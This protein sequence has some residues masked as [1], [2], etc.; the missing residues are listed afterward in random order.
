MAIEIVTSDV[1]VE[2]A[3]H[4]V[5][6]A[7][8]TSAATRRRGAAA[9]RDPARDR[10]RSA[11]READ[12]E[13][14]AELNIL[15]PETAPGRRRGAAAAAGAPQVS[16]AVGENE[17]AVVL[18]ET[19]GG[20]FNW[21]VADARAAAP[22]TR[23]GR[24]G[25]QMVLSFRIDAPRVAGDAGQRRGPVLDWIGEKLADPVRA[26]V[27]R[28][29]VTKTIDAAVKRI[30]G[31]NPTGPVLIDSIDP[32][33]WIPKPLARVLPQ[34]R[35]ARI[36]LMVHGT[37]SSTGGSF[38]QLAGNAVG[39]AFL[40]AA[41]AGY[42]I[43]LGHDH[44]TLADDPR[45]NAEAMLATLTALNPPPGSVID[46]VAF[47]RGGLVYRVFAEQLLAPAGLDVT[48]GK[49]IFVGCT[50][51]G[52]NLAEPEN[53][54]DMVDLYTNAVMAAA[55]GIALLS[56]SPL[57]PGVGFAI[58]TL[59]RFVQ[60][61][62][63]V[64]I[65]ERKLPGLAA[66]EPDGALVAALNAVPDAARI[67]NYHAVTS[68]FEPKRGDAKGFTRA[69]SKFVADR[70]TDRLFAAPN[71]LVVHTGSM[72]QF[73]AGAAL[74]PAHIHAFGDTGLIYHTIYF[75][76][77][78]VAERL[79]QWLGLAAKKVTPLAPKTSTATARR[80]GGG[81]RPVSIGVPPAPPSRPRNDIDPDL[82]TVTF[83]ASG[84]ASAAASVRA[85]DAMLSVSPVIARPVAKARKGRSSAKPAAPPKRRRGP[86]PETPPPPDTVERYLAAEM[87]PYPPIGA[88]VNVFVIVSPDAIR[89]AAHAAAATSDAP[90][91]IDA[92]RTLT[93][94]L[95]PRRN[96]RLVDGDDGR[97]EIDA[98]KPSEIITRLRVQGEA[99][100]DAELIVEARQ[101]SRIIAS[102]VLKPIFV[103]KNA[104]SLSQSQPLTA[105][106]ADED[107]P[108]LRIYEFRDSGSRITLRFD[109]MGDNPTVALSE[110]LTL[111][112]AFNVG[113]YVG[114][115]L[116][117]VEA[118]WNLAPD[119]YDAFLASFSDSAILRANALMPLAIRTALWNGRGAIKAI[120]IISDEA[121]IPWELLFIADPSGQSDERRGVL[122]EWGVVRW[123]HGVQR[124]PRTIGFTG[125]NSRSVIP[126]YRD[127][128][129]SLDGVAQ[130]HA[131]LKKLL[132]GIA[133]VPATSLEVCRFLRD[134]SAT[135]D[136]LHF[137]CHGES[138][139]KAVL[140]AKLLMEGNPNIDGST[141]EDGLS[142]DQ[143]KVNLRMATDRPRS[144]VFLN[145]CQ[146]GRGGRGIAGVSGFADSFI[147]PL[148]GHGAAVFV[149][150][151]WSIETTL[152]ENFA[153]TFYGALKS[154]DTLV[155]AVA[156]ARAACKQ[157]GD[158]TWL[159]YTIFGHPLARAAVS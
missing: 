153:K 9:A 55:R 34:D 148:S 30:E 137:A 59:G 83:G 8:D 80:G 102:F 122:S 20:V 42:D 140:T 157:Q 88:P 71:D 145:S 44:A 70:I 131:M 47:S 90:V 152:A 124:P 74:D 106:A 65:S 99:P 146:T 151:L 13:I 48:L 110:T 159:A 12:F 127:P 100:G 132:P 28:F 60:M 81:R 121:L 115:V 53:W 64:A 142:A 10:L 85:L 147:R 94:E 40:D 41:I 84:P 116:A 3:G 6:L 19:D 150:A 141:R 57:P 50:N 72:I 108:V 95:I 67:A 155:D 35:P 138:A 23:R 11:L 119:S 33:A 92:G 133:P 149:G 134:G 130:E 82:S 5:T 4:K 56:G 38:G 125:A 26:Y 143:V 61:F 68:S 109:L 103:A 96:C 27:L 104:A 77:V 113:A 101:G 54:A 69:L 16:V 25:R 51:G 154:G 118:A 117:E 120:Q 123:F 97:V 73:G 18:L 15:P 93:V 29:V 66:M 105:P 126:T 37:F 135:L 156:A 86:Q 144:L 76:D 7:S 31:D 17:S 158:F 32:V 75:G 136:V 91:A 45:A 98:A 129:L 79:S 58:R 24:G 128:A 39:R 62:S 114:G 87:E 52:T 46:A 63:E 22:G 107:F 112:P 111:D 2:T 49:A 1:F 21:Q 89:V 139:D 43:V 36:L 78:A 14:A